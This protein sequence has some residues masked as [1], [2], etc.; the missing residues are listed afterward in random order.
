M[1]F[2]FTCRLFGS[3]SSS[4]NTFLVGFTDFHNAH[5][6][7][8]QHEKSQPHILSELAYR[9][10]AKELKCITVDAS[11]V[12]QT[13]DEMKYW[14]DILKRIVAV[15]RF[16]GSR[17]LAFR[18]ANQVCGSIHNGNFLGILDLLSEFDP[19]ISSHIARHGNKGRGNNSLIISYVSHPSLLEFLGR[20][21]YLSD[22]ICDEFISLIGEKVL[23][24]ILA[25]I[26]DA[27]YFSISVDS[28]P[29]VSHCDQLVF[30]VRYVRN[31]KP[32][33]RFLQFIPI[34]QHK[35]E[36]LT[37]TVIDFMRSH[38]IDFSNCRG[39]SYDN[40]NNMAGKYSGL[41]KRILD[42]NKFAIFLPCAAH[43][44]NLIGSAAVT[45][46][47]KAASFFCFM[48]HLYSFF[49]TSTSRWDLLKEALG[50]DK[51]LLKRA[52]GT[53][54]SAKFDSVDAL[55]Y[56]ILEVKE[57]LLK[58]INDDSLQ[59][60]DQ[61]KVLANGVLKQLC[62]FANILMLKV[63]HAILVKFD[64]VNHMLQKSD[65][66]LSV[67]VKL[68]ETLINHVEGLSSKFEDFF[69]DAKSVYLDMDAETHTPRY[70]AAITLENME[71]QKQNCNKTMFV[72]VIQL[73][74]N[75][76]KSRM[77]SYV[78][79]EEKFCFLIKLDEIS[80]DDISTPCQKIASFYINDIDEKDLINEC[81]L[82]KQYFFNDPSFTVS[83][84]SMYSKI[85][86]DELQGLFPNIEIVLRIFLSLFVTNVPDERSFSKLKHIKNIL[87]NRLSEEKL[88]SL[89]LMSIE[90]E[91]LNSINFDEI[92]NEFVLLK[93]RK[94]SI[95][96][97]SV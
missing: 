2:C 94:R 36:Y 22:T 44:L 77:A 72:P 42:M 69:N 81:E 96:V 82:A 23:N 39:Q 24:I 1:I 93:T 87:R 85:I 13:E 4:S 56:N 80:L 48:E 65:L 50:A 91:I 79:M 16:L 26:R 6:S 95:G 89:S 59:T 49:V 45:K 10:R 61:N 75:N 28:T 84:A 71:D 86:K 74:K 53:R 31:D 76:L 9:I 97:E 32:V 11:I 51:R 66:N 73:L 60:T 18:G 17:G 64:K 14:R 15:I 67:T 57:V 12:N 46:N 68:Y 35:S 83:H 29:D 43:S 62:T 47:S 54:W 55:N 21:S 52:T 19:L 37:E 70:R 38:S 34:N 8:Q 90:N 92:I 3:S 63:W 5:R 58:L 7:F 40:T 30:C 27:K 78:D 41:Q 88:N 33:E 25:E 20:A